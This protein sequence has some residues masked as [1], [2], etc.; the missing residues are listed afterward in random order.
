[1][2]YEKMKLTMNIKNSGIVSGAGT[3]CSYAGV[4]A[5]M[6]GVSRRNGKE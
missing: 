4:I 3:V 6:P 1:M 5:T 2:N